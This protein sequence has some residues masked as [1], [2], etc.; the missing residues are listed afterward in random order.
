MSTVT[1]YTVTKHHATSRSDITTSS[2]CEAFA[3]YC[4]GA[5]QWVSHV[6]VLIDGEPVR[7]EVLEACAVN[8]RRDAAG[9]SPL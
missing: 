8:E 9:R 7:P 5:V 6:D 4:R 1:T 3:F 2:A